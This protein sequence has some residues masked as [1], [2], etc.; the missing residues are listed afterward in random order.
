LS[1][2]KHGSKYHP[3]DVIFQA[4][5]HLQN[6]ERLDFFLR[7]HEGEVKALQHWD[8]PITDITGMGQSL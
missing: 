2:F 4:S 8:G 1:S 6:T 5:P 7:E 3:S